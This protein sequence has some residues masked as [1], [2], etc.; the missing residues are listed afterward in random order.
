MGELL[1]IAEIALVALIAVVLIRFRAPRWTFAVLAVAATAVFSLVWIELGWYT[2]ASDFFVAAW[3]GGY[4]L[5]TLLGVRFMS[6]RSGGLLHRLGGGLAGGV[7]CMFGVS[8]L[9]LVFYFA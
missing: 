2:D 3:T 6:R 4:V 8:L 7:V 9:Y 1:A 5:G